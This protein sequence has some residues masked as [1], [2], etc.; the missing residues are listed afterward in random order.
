MI[1]SL[2]PWEVAMESRVCRAW[3]KFFWRR[4]LIFAWKYAILAS[5]ARSQVTREDCLLR[6]LLIA[7][8]P[9]T[10]ILS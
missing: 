3:M 8:S 9:T 2:L 1:R 7:A 6:A 10:R 4:E 5:P